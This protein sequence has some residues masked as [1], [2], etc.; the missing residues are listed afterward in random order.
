MPGVRFSLANERTAR[1]DWLRYR[2]AEQAIREGRDLSTG[3]IGLV[4]VAGISVVL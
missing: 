2:Q 4:V 3:I 1:G